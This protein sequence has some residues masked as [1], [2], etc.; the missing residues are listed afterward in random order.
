MLSIS[1]GQ[2]HDNP[3]YMEALS[4]RNIAHVR[5]YKGK[6]EY[7]TA[8]ILLRCIKFNVDDVAS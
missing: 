5:R 4:G 2:D 7:S 1:L 3:T 6:Q 8:V